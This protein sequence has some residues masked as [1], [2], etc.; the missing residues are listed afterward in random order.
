MQ[1][2]QGPNKKIV[3]YKQIHRENSRKAKGE[4]KC[5]KVTIEESQDK[6]HSRKYGREK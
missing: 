1:L 2:I 5:I 4:Q 6:I 3:K